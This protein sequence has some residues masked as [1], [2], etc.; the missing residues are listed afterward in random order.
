MWVVFNEGWGQYATERL[1]Q[2]VKRL[3]PRRLVCAASGWHDLPGAG[4]V[5]DIHAYPGP[6]APEPEAGRAAVL[7]EFGGLGL[8]IPGHLW[9]AERNWGYRNLK[10][11]EELLAGYRGLAEKLRPL[12]ARP[13]LSAAVYTQLTDVESEVNGLMTYDRAVLK[14]DAEALARIHEELRSPP[15]R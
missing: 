2:D 12:I 3:D 14:V 11:G 10:S 5:H 7:G 8:P 1:A 6:R 4:D 13:G 9:Q 15:P